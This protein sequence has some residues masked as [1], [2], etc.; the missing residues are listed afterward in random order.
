MSWPATWA[1]QGNKRRRSGPWMA[2]GASDSVVPRGHDDG[3]HVIVRTKSPAGSIMKTLTIAIALLLT[4]LPAAAQNGRAGF[5][6]AHP[7]RRPRPRT[8][9]SLPGGRSQLSPRGGILCRWRKPRCRASS[10]SA[11]AKTAS[12]PAEAQITLTEWPLDTTIV[13]YAFEI[14]P[15]LVGDRSANSLAAFPDQQQLPSGHLPALSHEARA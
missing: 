11:F 2:R 12:S 13:R 1:I 10:P 7:R 4:A 3:E 15:Q 8:C 5:P 9:L 6:P 14:T